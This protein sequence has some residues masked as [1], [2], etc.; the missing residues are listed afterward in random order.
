MEEIVKANINR[1]LIF[2]IKQY[3]QLKSFGSLNNNDSLVYLI[4]KYLDKHL[5]SISV[6]V[7]LP[8]K[9]YDYWV[10]YEYYNLALK[11]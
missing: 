5:L 6:R 10:T 4:N 1:N 2:S 3:S 8:I 11:E 7:H 9:F